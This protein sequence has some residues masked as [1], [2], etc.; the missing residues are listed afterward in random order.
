M[1]V[2]SYNTA[3]LNGFKYLTGEKRNENS[4]QNNFQKIDKCFLTNVEIER[5]SR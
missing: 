2:F 3:C 1:Y 4:D 5:F